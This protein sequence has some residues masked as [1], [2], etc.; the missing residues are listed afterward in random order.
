MKP[1]RRSTPN[2]ILFPAPGLIKPRCFFIGIKKR[3]II[4]VQLDLWRLWERLNLIFMY[5]PLLVM[6]I[7]QIIKG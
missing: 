6:S 5:A 7:R 4:V 1:H 3:I 2:L